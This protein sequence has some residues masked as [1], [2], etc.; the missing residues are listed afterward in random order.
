VLMANGYSHLDVDNICNLIKLS[1]FAN[2]SVA[3]PDLIYDMFTKPLHVSSSQIKEFL[4]LFGK[5]SVFEKI[6]GGK[7]D[8]IL[9][10]YVET[11]TSRQVNPL[12]VKH[13]GKNLRPD[14]LEDARKKLFHHKIKE[15]M[16]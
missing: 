10:K 1:H 5:Q 9:K 16:A 14:E 15:L 12:Y 4:K 7:L 3:N 8:D 2:S 6:F 11:E 13:M